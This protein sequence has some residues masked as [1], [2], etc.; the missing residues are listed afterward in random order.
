MKPLYDNLKQF[1]YT[2]LERQS[3][4]TYRYGFN[5]QEKDD[6][7]KGV[8]NSYEF[9]YRVH[10]SRLGKFLSV[11]P[12]SKDYPWNS[13]YAFAE[14]DLIR[15]IDLE[16]L[17]K[18]IVTARTFIP[19]EKLPN[20]T[21]SP[22]FTSSSFGGDNRYYYTINDASYRTEQKVVADFDANL[23][24]FTNNT[25]SGSI[26]Y[27]KNGNVVEIS[28]PTTAGTIRTT[29]NTEMT[30]STTIYL[31]VNAS[32]LLVA[33]APAINYDLAVTITPSS[34]GKTFD[35][36]IKGKTNGFP[37]YEL[38]ITD[39]T[40]NNSYLLFNQSPTLL[41]EGAGSLFPPMEHEYNLKGNSSTVNPSTTNT[42]DMT[43]NS[44]ECD[45][46]C[47]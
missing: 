27:D 17:E 43:P 24:Y 26:G 28:A 46:D 20:P 30:T 11:D 12:L 29:P 45:D 36:Q 39:Q 2:K 15:A 6:G 22:N 19:M 8:G 25:A 18:Y 4:E 34:D 40:N 5:G 35:Y 1:L 7:V 44:A 42:F 41:N 10:D 38:W 31:T 32:N 14:N 47:E 37:A 9:K 13:P 23:L 33:G 16:G 3:F 21:Y